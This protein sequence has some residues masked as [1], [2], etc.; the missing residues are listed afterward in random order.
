[1]VGSRRR[2][3]PIEGRMSD[4]SRRDIIAAAA[5]TGVA[6]ASSEAMAEGSPM[7][8]N[9]SYDEVKKLLQLEPNATCG[10]VRVTYESKLR[11]A[12]GGLPTPF[13]D[14]R[15][16]GSALFFMLTPE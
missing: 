8:G 3:K 13:A 5:L 11:I 9:M 1:M 6:L 2:S 7:H 15:P 4:H 16:T 12:P 14:G 10:Y